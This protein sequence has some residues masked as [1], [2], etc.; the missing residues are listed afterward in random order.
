ML[1]LRRRS[2]AWPAIAILTCTAVVVAGCASPGSPRPPSLHLPGAV[3]NLTAVRSGNE[4]QLRFALPHNTTD[5]QS[6]AGALLHGSL[7][8]EEAVGG[9]CRV[10]EAKGNGATLHVPDTSSEDDAVVWTDTLPPE[11]CAGAPRPLAYRIALSNGEGRSA[12]ASDPV[13]AAAGQ[14]PG[15]VQ[16]FA[17]LGS[18]SGVL[19]SWTATA[20]TGEILL[21]RTQLDQKPAARPTSVPDAAP[22]SNRS[23]PIANG[24]TGRAGTADPGTVWM[25]VGSG[26]TEGGET[27]DGTVAEG[28]RYRYTAV[29]Q[30]T[31]RVGGRSLVLRSAPSD[32]VEVTWRDVFPPPAPQQLTALGYASGDD[33]AAYAVDLIWQPVND[34]GVA[35]YLVTRLALDS[36][37][38]AEGVPAR[39]NVAPVKVPGFHDLTADPARGYEYT[40]RAIDAKGHMSAAATAMVSSQSR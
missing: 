26:R 4:V 22:S 5:G 6:L 17:A 20:G 13:Y 33:H 25:Q 39:L 36:S 34:P 1:S 27:I 28:V 24:R 29:R 11:L 21:E 32:P 31:A 7:C 14:A 8:R 10:V 35:G 40:V 18:R 16:Q 38:K 12:G 9:P 15:P 30:I 37:G 3:T 2:G 23:R 19:L